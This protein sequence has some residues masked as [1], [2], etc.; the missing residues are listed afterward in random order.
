MQRRDA[1]IIGEHRRPDRR[2]RRRPADRRPD[3]VAVDRDARVL[4]GERRDVGRRAA[5][6]ARPA[7]G[8]A[9]REDSASAFGPIHG[10][11]VQTVEMPPRPRRRTRRRSRPARSG[12][13][14]T[15]DRGRAADADARRA[16][17]RGRR[18]RARGSSGTRCCTRTSRCPRR[19]PALKTVWPWAA[20]CSKSRFSAAS[21]PGRQ[22]ELVGLAEAPRRRHDPRA[23]V[24]DDPV[25]G[26]ERAVAGVGRL[27]DVDLGAPARS[28]RR[29][30]RR[31]PPRRRRG[32]CPARRR[33]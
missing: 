6:L 27:V 20:A 23:V 14:A 21:E 24:R 10:G 13:W 17:R 8:T 25:V 5:D 32:P 1:L 7:R 30:R 28:P 16:G 33:R 9:S 15:R 31:G 4:V 3:A 29:S 11:W 12:G 19:P 18:R 2:G 22:V 26:V